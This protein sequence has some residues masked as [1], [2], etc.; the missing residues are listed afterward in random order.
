MERMTIIYIIAAIVIVGLALG[1][2]LGLGLKKD[3]DDNNNNNNNDNKITYTYYGDKN[4]KNWMNIEDTE[5]NLYDNS[6]EFKK[7]IDRVTIF[8][9][10][11]GDGENPIIPLLK[12]TKGNPKSYIV[13]EITILGVNE[14][15]VLDMTSYLQFQTVGFSD[16]PKYYFKV[17]YKK[18]GEWVN[19]S[20]FIIQ[21][22]IN[23]NDLLA[24]KNTEDESNINTNN[25]DFYILIYFLNNNGNITEQ[26]RG[27]S[28]PFTF[29]TDLSQS[30]IHGY[31]YKD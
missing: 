1:L 13:G 18:N 6:T 4:Y 19:D 7:L 12:F 28:V 29:G 22:D 8:F 26:V 9:Q 14:N 5:G 27:G 3:D 20:E 11:Q 10:E 31:G 16:F 2:G 24:I 23:N 25:W 17:N 30:T 21:K 15:L